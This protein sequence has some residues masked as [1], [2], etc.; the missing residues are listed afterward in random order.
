MKHLVI[1]VLF[2]LSA[3][4]YLAGQNLENPSFDSVYFG[5]I[6][7]LF[8][9]ITSDGLIFTTG[10]VGDTAYPLQPQTAY[11]ATGFQFHEILWIGNRITTSPYSGAAIEL[12]SRPK[13]KKVDGTYYETFISN[14]NYFSTDSLGYPELHTCGIPFNSRPL[15]LL[16]LYRFTDSTTSGNTYGK[17]VIWL[18]KWNQATRQRDTIAFVEST[19]A[20]QP[21]NIVLPFILPLTYYSIATPDT[22]GVTFYASTNPQHAATLWLDEL[23]LAYNSTHLA[24]QTLNHGQL[25]PMPVRQ[26]LYYHGKMPNG[27]TYKICTLQGQGL[28]SGAWQGIVDV[29]DLPTGVYTFHLVHRGEILYSDKFLKTQ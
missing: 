22:L 23:S 24:E 3:I 6:D 18:H 17:C 20:L 5:G 12:C 25:F 26:K 27:V 8:S 21:T 9:W 28:R 14:G 13:W 1:S 16:G 4:P 7:R 29:A 11:H 10:T 2:V 19:T 15:A